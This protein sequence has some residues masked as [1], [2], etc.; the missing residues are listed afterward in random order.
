[1]V[2]R[3]THHDASKQRIGIK[4]IRAPT[5]LWWPSVLKLYPHLSID[6]LVHYHRPDINL[7]PHFHSSFLEFARKFIIH[8]DKAP[9]PLIKNPKTCFGLDK[10]FAQIV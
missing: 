1:M 4:S 7:L 8:I 2:F 6:A 3:I 9:I 5:L 10:T